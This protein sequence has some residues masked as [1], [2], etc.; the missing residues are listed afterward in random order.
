MPGFQFLSLDQLEKNIDVLLSKVEEKHKGKVATDPRSA[1]VA[2]IKQVRAQLKNVTHVP[3]KEIENEA[4]KKARK[5]LHAQW[6]AK[7]AD[8]KQLADIEEK[9]K[10]QIALLNKINAEELKLR[11]ERNALA[12]FIKKYRAEKTVSD[13]ASSHILND[14]ERAVILTGMLLSIKKSIENV[15][16]GPSLTNKLISAAAWISG[17]KNEASNSVFFRGVDEAIGNTGE[18]K[19][20][21]KEAEKAIKTYNQYVGVIE[22]LKAKLK[23]MEEGKVKLKHVDTKVKQRVYGSH[24]DHVLELDR[25]DVLLDTAEEKA[26]YKKYTESQLAYSKFKSDINPLINE[27]VQQGLSHVKLEDENIDKTRFVT[28]DKTRFVTD[29]SL[30]KLPNGQPA[31]NKT[32]R[33]NVDPTHYMTG[34]TL[35]PVAKGDKEVK[36]TAEQEKSVFAAS[37]SFFAKGGLKQQIE[38]QSK[39]KHVVEPKKPEVISCRPGGKR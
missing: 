25:G 34:V 21:E 6:Q 39:L 24:L 1:H 5:E 26:R 38:S 16:Y 33:D 32:I 3:N 7:I 10:D 12:K 30:A 9:T 22:E 31:K 37:M 19:I 8:S 18:N 2:L 27:S 36:W 14:Q 23:Q 17:G 13:V 28:T 35:A 15:E 20:D 11:I 4:N 29:E